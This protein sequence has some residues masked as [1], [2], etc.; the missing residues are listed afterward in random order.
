MTG[1]FHV[2][3]EE[4]AGKGDAH[5]R[6]NPEKI[7][8]ANHCLAN[9]GRRG[10]TKFPPF[11]PKGAGR[12]PSQAPLTKQVGFRPDHDAEQILKGCQVLGYKN[13]SQMINVAI[14]ALALK[15]LAPSPA[16]PIYVSPSEKALAI[17]ALLEPISQHPTH[18]DKA[19]KAEIIYTVQ[20]AIALLEPIS[21][22]PT[23][24]D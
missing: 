19:T 7:A 15:E 21:Q 17:I 23:H 5:K 8:F 22:H 2:W 24:W 13:Q 6:K 14:K 3:W 1:F 12:K 18:W 16:P 11:N 9:I 4:F 10:M 20:E